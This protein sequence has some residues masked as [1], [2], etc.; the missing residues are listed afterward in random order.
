MNS[1]KITLEVTLEEHDVLLS[2][3]NLLRDA[4]GSMYISRATLTEGDALDAHKALDSLS[5][6]VRLMWGER[7]NP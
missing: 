7:F 1:D 6:K 5:D 4:Q 2:A 3:L